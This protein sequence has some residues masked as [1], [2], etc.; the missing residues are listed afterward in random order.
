MGEI[1]QEQVMEAKIT[2]FEVKVASINEDE[3]SFLHI[4]YIIAEILKIL[5]T[6]FGLAGEFSTCTIPGSKNFVKCENCTKTEE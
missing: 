4:L 1:K 2:Q 5:Q 3:R 6:P